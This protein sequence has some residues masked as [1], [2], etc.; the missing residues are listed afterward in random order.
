MTLSQVSLKEAVDLIRLGRD[1]ILQLS[2]EHMLPD[3]ATTPGRV[4]SGLI[5]HKNLP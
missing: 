4:C 2:S 5:I 3:V 1:I